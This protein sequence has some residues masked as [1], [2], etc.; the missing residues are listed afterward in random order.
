MLVFVFVM[1]RLVSL[2]FAVCSIALGCSG[3]PRHQDIT[4]DLQF[5]L[6][7]KKDSQS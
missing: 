6:F 1:I 3:L 2:L 7:V 4:L 5:L